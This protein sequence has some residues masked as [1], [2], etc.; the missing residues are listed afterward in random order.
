MT[1]K[2]PSRELTATPHVDRRIHHYKSLK[3]GQQLFLFYL[4]RQHG[5][6]AAC[7][8]K[9]GYHQQDFLNWATRGAVPYQHVLTVADCLSLHETVVF[10]LNYKVLSAVYQE[11]P[12]WE[13]VVEAAE[14]SEKATKRI[15]KAKKPA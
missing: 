1:T 9:C 10:G 7:A 6:P 14:F 13:Q 8:R 5:G 15:L 3:T 2:P 11:S 4:W 12:E